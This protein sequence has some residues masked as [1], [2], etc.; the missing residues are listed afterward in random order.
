[1]LQVK[2]DKAEKELRIFQEESIKDKRELKRAREEWR[3]E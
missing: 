3:R 2:W 1:M